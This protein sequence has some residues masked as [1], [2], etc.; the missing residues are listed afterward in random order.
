MQ[1]IQFIH[2]KKICLHN[3]QT[4]RN[5]IFLVFFKDVY[6]NVATLCVDP[7]QENTTLSRGSNYFSHQCTL[8]T[9]IINVH[10]KSCKMLLTMWVMHSRLIK[11]LNCQNINIIKMHNTETYTVYNKSL[12]AQVFIEIMAL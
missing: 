3:I 9:H 8:H 2:W 5:T 10:N 7:D 11:A 12:I 6:R 4:L 1:K